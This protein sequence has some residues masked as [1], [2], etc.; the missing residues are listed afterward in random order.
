M[1]KNLKSVFLVLKDQWKKKKEKDQWKETGL[2]EE[3]VPA[4]IILLVFTE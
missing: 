3:R 2:G 1:N 4:K